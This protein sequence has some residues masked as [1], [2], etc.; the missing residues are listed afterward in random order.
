[1]GSL[2]IKMGISLSTHTRRPTGRIMDKTAGRQQSRFGRLYIHFKEECL[3]THN[4]QYYAPGESFNCKKVKV[5][6]KTWSEL[7]VTDKRFLKYLG[8]MGN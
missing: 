1:M 7:S 8:I 3:E 5:N 4:D 6:S 2:S